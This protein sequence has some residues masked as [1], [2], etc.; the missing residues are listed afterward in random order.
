MKKLLC[1]FVDWLMITRDPDLCKGSEIGQYG[2]LHFWEHYGYI[3]PSWMTARDT[4]AHVL[5]HWLGSDVQ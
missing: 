1:S 5:G 4:D 2:D 3:H